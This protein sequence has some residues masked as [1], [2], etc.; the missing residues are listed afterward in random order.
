[1]L[2]A[3]VEEQDAAPGVDHG[4]LA[5]DRPVDGYGRGE[6][7]RALPLPADRPEVLPVPVERLDVPVVLVE[8]V[9]GSVGAFRDRR[10][11]GEEGVGARVAAD[12]ELL[13]ERERL[14]AVEGLGGVLDTMIPPSFTTLPFQTGG[15]WE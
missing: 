1:M 3:C 14:G 2:A 9:N 4:Q 12:R 6:L 7:A 8:D 15:F 11:R 13:D 10:D 5:P